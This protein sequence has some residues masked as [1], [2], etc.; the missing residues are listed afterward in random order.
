MDMKVKLLIVVLSPL[1]VG[2]GLAPF[3]GE[4]A[5]IPA[6]IVV[7]LGIGWLIGTKNVDKN[8]I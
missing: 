5:G 7:A 3:I 8:D 4:W 2:L 1:V 6:A